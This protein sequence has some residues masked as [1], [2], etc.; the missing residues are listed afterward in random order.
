M[1]TRMP[2]DSLKTIQ[3]LQGSHHYWVAEGQLESGAIL[4]K[5]GGDYDWEI[6]GGL[7]FLGDTL[8]SQKQD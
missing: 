4:W 8:Q 5:R 2:Q 6:Y 1:L 3:I 7:P